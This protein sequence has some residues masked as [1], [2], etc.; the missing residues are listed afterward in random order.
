MMKLAEELVREL[1]PWFV[2]YRRGWMN[3]MTIER[4]WY[5]S[6]RMNS[7]YEDSATI[8]NDHLMNGVL[9]KL[10]EMSVFSSHMKLTC[11]STRSTSLFNTSSKNA[12]VDIEKARLINV[13]PCSSVKYMD[14]YISYSEEES[15]KKRSQT[16]IIESKLSQ[17]K[18]MEF[19]KAS[20]DAYVEKLYARKAESYIS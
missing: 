5:K 9:N 3:S 8:R 20:R 16:L 10:S 12:D 14:Y 7:W 13:I 6:D 18:I 4:V 1:K 11:A 19:V 2:K 15:E 17:S